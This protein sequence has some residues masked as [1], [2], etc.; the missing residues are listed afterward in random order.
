MEIK[1]PG[2]EGVVESFAPGSGQVKLAQGESVTYTLVWDQRDSGG[3]QVAPGYYNPNIKAKD[4]VIN[5]R[6]AGGIGTAVK[7]LIQYP[8]GAMEKTIEVNQSQTANGFTI[9]LERV[10]LT[11][12]ATKFYA[13]VIPPDY[14]PPEGEDAELPPHRIPYL[15]DL[16]PVHATYTFDGVTKDARSADLDIRGDGI[17]LAWAHPFEPLDPVPADAKELTFTIPR[18]GD[19]EGPWEFKI[20]LE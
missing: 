8:Q 11:S 16:R 10:E 6:A 12:M 1:L 13:F 18:F 20:P 5:G 9:T 14:S 7:V 19:W 4:I 17:I 15:S 2:Q 3:R